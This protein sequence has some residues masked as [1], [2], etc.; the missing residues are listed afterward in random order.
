MIRKTI[1]NLKENLEE[2]TRKAMLIDIF[3]RDKNGSIKIEKNQKHKPEIHTIVFYI[4]PKKN[5]ATGNEIFI[6]KM[7]LQEM[8]FLSQIPQKMKF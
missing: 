3:A 2:E 8:R 7:K 6:K 5:E 4:Q 1:K